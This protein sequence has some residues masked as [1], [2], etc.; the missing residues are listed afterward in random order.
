MSTRTQKQSQLRKLILAALFAALI[1]VMTFTPY[2][3]YITYGIVEITTLHIV[4]ALGAMLLGWK[5]GAFL[6]GVW[7]VTCL[8]RAFAN[9]LWILFTNPLISMLPRILVG[10]IAG[11]VFAALSKTKLPQY[12]CAG[13]TG[14]VATLS[15]TILVLTSMYVFGDMVESY[16]EIFTLIKSIFGT[17]IGINGVIELVA[18]IIIVPALYKALEKARK[19]YKI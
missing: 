17:I 19:S 4:T 15:N 5:Y 1:T 11:L 7:G 16:R 2:F 13:I 8:I 14:A 10:I 12:V 9:P 18:A 3:G 6:G